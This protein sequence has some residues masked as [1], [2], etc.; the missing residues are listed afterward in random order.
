[1]QGSFRYRETNISKYD[2]SFLVHLWLII[3]IDLE[4]R[5]ENLIFIRS[6]GTLNHYLSNPTFESSLR[7]YS[8]FLFRILR[9]H[10]SN[11]HKSPKCG[12]IK[13]ID[14]AYQIPLLSYS[15]LL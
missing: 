12:V 15:H 4:P 2:T 3:I 14:V 1:M 13:V 11:L 6:Q 10:T 5:K 9:L 7:T 8:K